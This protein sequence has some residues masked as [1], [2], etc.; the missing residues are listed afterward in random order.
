MG[1]VSENDP[2]QTILFNLT[3]GLSQIVNV[4]FF[5]FFGLFRL[6]LLKNKDNFPKKSVRLF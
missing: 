5:T 4:N 6:L 1:G 3:K 2:S